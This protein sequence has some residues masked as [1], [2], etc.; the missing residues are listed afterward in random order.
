LIRSTLRDLA[1]LMPERGRLIALVLAVEALIAGI[2]EATLLVLVV[3]AA[4]SLTDGANTVEVAVPVLDALELGP[5]RAL[6]IA[7]AAAVVML[8]LH[9]HTAHLSSRLSSG[10]MRSVRDRALA[11]FSSASWAR[12]SQ[13]REGALQETVSAL[14]G[15]SAG[16]TMGLAGMLSAVLALAALLAGAL[17][18]DPLTTTIVLAFGAVS[19]W[20]SDR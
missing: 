6:G 16:L 2:L 11:A 4:L 10:V 20:R 14:A 7:G 17:A 13:A 5:A 3:S 9:L 12:Q 15:G 8:A 19:C 1:P 18:V